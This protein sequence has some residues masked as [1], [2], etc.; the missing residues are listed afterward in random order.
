MKFTN[1]Q[2]DIIRSAL[3]IAANVT[4]RE[5]VALYDD[6]PDISRSL[7]DE[8]ESYFSLRETIDI[9]REKDSE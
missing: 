9:D 7:I 5:A 8:S 6:A 3:G 4:Q 2:I 1:E